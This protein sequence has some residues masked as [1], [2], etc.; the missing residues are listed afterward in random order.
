MFIFKIDG[1]NMIKYQI[2]LTA[3]DTIKY[4]TATFE[5]SDE[6]N[7][8][9]K[10]VHFKQGEVIYDI[11][12]TNDKILQSD[13][14]NLTS[15]TWS[16]YI[17][18]N[19]YSG[20]TVI[21]RITTIPTTIEVVATNTLNGE[22]FPETPAS[23]IE[24]VNAKIDDVK[25]KVTI[26]QQAASSALESAEEAEE[27][28]SA[29][30]TSA[31]NAETSA[32]QATTVAQ[33]AKTTAE[34]KYQK[35]STGIPK[36]DLSS[37][38]QTSLE[39]ANSAY[40]KPSTGIPSTDMSSSVQTSLG[41]ADTALQE[42][43]SLSAYR[44]SAEQDVIDSEKVSD[45]KIN[46]TSIVTDG[47]GNVPMASYA[48]YGVIKGDGTG[49][50]GI[51]INSQGIP[52]I[53][54]ASSANIDARSSSRRP[55]IPS[56]L[57]YAVKS[58]MCD[59]RGADWTVS[60]CTNAKKR[61]GMIGEFEVI[62]D[63]T[64]E[65]EMASVILNI[66]NLANYSEIR[67]ETVFPVLTARTLVTYKFAPSEIL[68]DYIS[69]AGSTAYNHSIKHVMFFD[70]ENS[71]GTEKMEGFRIMSDQ[72]VQTLGAHNGNTALYALYNAGGNIANQSGIKITRTGNLP[73]G[74]KF[75]ILGR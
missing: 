38:V 50:Y 35:P 70:A 58:A 30:E 10:W 32:S 25:S 2:P 11:N 54:E 23:V 34:L 20:D 47:M 24:Q 27:S 28:A 39:K 22:P 16:I 21:Q 13:N 12:L 40:Q 61:I 60:E 55:I 42:H 73:V 9:D 59:G 14:L 75:R 15:G 3:S 17:H 45:I 4:L 33:E 46:G 53:N 31:Q 18:G 56:N 6:W 57:D 62:V 36:S 51:N 8:L 7:G 64:L 68:I 74:T 41:L 37:E 49:A 43:Q 67:I 26:A 52:Y 1:Q 48:E 69:S 72:A 44:T 65:E 5:F 29:A 63:T 66:P 71:I 19:K